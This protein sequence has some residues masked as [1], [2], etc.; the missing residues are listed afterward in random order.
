MKRSFGMTEPLYN[1]QSEAKH[2]N[3]G[4]IKISCYDIQS[5]RSLGP[6]IYDLVHSSI[7]NC[8]SLNHLRKIIKSW[9]PKICPC[10]LCKTMFLRYICCLDISDC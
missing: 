10:R 2:F 5:V 9:K 3:R 6:K 7:K 1:F 8:N 4:N